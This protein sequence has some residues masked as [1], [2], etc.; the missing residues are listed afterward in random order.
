[1]KHLKLTT[2]LIAILGVHPMAVPAQEE[3]PFEVIAV[4]EL[5]PGGKYGGGVEGGQAPLGYVEL[6][7]VSA[8]PF[9]PGHWE[10]NHLHWVPDVRYPL[11][12]PRMGGVFRNIYAPSAIEEGD[13][14]RFFYAA[15][16]GIESGT[17]RVYSAFTPDFVDFYD[18]HTVIH[19]GEFIHVSNVNV[20]QLED[21]SLHMYA[22]AYPDS[23][24]TNRPIHFYSPDGKTWN[25]SP[26]PYH[27]RQADLVEIIGYEPES[28]PNFNG[29]NVLLYDKGSF[30]VYFTN[31]RDRGKLYWAEGK[32]PAAVQ[33]GGLALETGYAVNDV[34][35]FTADGKGWYLMALHKKGDASREQHDVNRLFFSLSNDGKN[36]GKEQLM[37]ESMGEMDRNIFAVGFV[38]RKD[39]ILGVLYGA[40]PSYR[41]NRNQIFGY[42]LQKRVMLKAD[43]AGRGAEYEA[44]GALGPDRQWIKLPPLL[45]PMDN[46]PVNVNFEGTLTVFAEDGITPLGTREVSLRPG[47]VYRLVWK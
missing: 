10:T 29:A 26:E 3:A 16:D 31:W 42:W 19:N 35:K 21:G 18:R 12:A 44:E 11:M 47:T 33:F 32:N 4:P 36:F 45:P 34:K 28:K 41:S 1:M 39:R 8:G 13:G 15:W 14:W 6:Q 20:Q 2:L 40:G 46:E 9:N 17:D 7:G 37:V 38:T 24:R 27:A 25:G 30:M 22:T 43:R 23:Q 5:P